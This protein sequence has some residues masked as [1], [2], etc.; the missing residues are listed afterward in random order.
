MCPCH[1]N[2][3]IN[4]CSKTSFNFFHPM[5]NEREFT[6]DMV[7]GDKFYLLR[8][9]EST[10]FWSC[11]NGG[12]FMWKQVSNSI[13][14][15]LE[16]GDHTFSKLEISTFQCDRHHITQFNCFCGLKMCYDQ[17]VAVQIQNTEYWIILITAW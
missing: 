10:H 12:K 9:F 8:T 3:G 6:E 11:S 2:D 5:M 7:K 14:N 4:L 15:I 17:E 1:W 16:P 13:Y